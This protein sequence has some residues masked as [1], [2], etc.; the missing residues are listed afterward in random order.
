MTD[1][2]VTDG[3]EALRAEIRRLEGEL[4]TE[5]MRLAACGV[6]AMAN[7]SDSAERARV[8]ADEY[9]SAS[10][11]DVCAVVDREMAYRRALELIRE[12]FA[13]RSEP[14]FSNLVDYI[15]TFLRPGV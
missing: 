9:W 4:E 14:R 7:T 15:D 6:V 10:L 5:R 2:D 12:A 11:E 13:E 3:L 8:M 1:L